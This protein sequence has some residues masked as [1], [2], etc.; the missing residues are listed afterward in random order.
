MHVCLCTTCVLAF[1]EAKEGQVR[2]LG[3]RVRANQVTVRV[4]GPLEVQPVILTT[5]PISVVCMSMCIECSAHGCP[6]CEIPLELKFPEVA[7]CLTWQLRTELW[8][9]GKGLQDI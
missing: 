3:T 9:S 4:L 1:K 5:E 7:N 6:H 2:C 8:S